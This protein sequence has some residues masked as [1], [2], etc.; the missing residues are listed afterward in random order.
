MIGG[1]YAARIFACIASVLVG[2]P[3]AANALTYSFNLPVGLGGITGLVVTDGTLG[4]LAQDNFSSIGLTVSDGSF[5]SPVG[6][7]SMPGPSSFANPAL[8]AT[9]TGLFY[10]FSYGSNGYVDV[11]NV[12][13]AYFCL[14]G[15]IACGGYANGA[16]LQ[17]GAQPVA[18]THYIGL[19]QIASIAEVPVP[20]TAWLFLPVVVGLG[21]AGM[22][23]RKAKRAPDG[24]T[25]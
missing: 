9:A 25:T 10:D 3:S 22:R 12:G 6:I 23:N 24:R 4:A 2:I 19:T 21:A 15:N 7:I 13:S 17:I 1:K 16:S 18:F 14:T 5:S 11:Y 20:A 8:T